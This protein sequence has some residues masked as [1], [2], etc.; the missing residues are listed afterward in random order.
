[1]IDE[2]KLA[3]WSGANYMKRLIQDSQ[4]VAV[5][6]FS[7]QTIT[8]SHNLGHIPGELVVAMNIANDGTLWVN[9]PY[10]DPLIDTPLYPT[11]NY[12]ADDNTLTIRVDNQ[13]SGTKTMTVYWVIYMDYA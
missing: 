2:S 6:A 10:Y 5:S 11:F 8:V 1:M 3:F 7:S 12:W 9:N 13:T 4:D